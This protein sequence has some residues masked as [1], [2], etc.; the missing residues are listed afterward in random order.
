MK[1]QPTF[2][3]KKYLGNRREVLIK[4]SQNSTAIIIPNKEILNIFFKIRDMTTL[5]NITLL[6]KHSKIKK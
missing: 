1:I 2:I 3:V 4:R 5:L 6:F